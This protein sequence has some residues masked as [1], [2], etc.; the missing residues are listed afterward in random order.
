MQILATF[1]IPLFSEASAIGLLLIIG[2][3]VGVIVFHHAICVAIAHLFHPHVL[4]IVLGVA[5]VGLLLALVHG[6]WVVPGPAN[7]KVINGTDVVSV[8]AVG[9]S[10]NWV[11][12]F[13]LAA[14]VAGIVVAVF[15]LSG[16]IKL[17][18]APG[19]I[20]LAM[21]GVAG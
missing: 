9:Q 19:W 11:K 15:I 5:L 17:H 3:V 20:L 10:A 8:E 6:F 21:V 12:L 18:I 16:Q 7:V 4:G 13:F 2:I 14:V 1:L